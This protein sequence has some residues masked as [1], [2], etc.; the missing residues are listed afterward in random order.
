MMG[1]TIGMESIEGKGSTFWFTARF[2]LQDEQLVNNT[3]TSKKVCSTIAGRRLLIVEDNPALCEILSHHCLSWGV[4]AVIAESGKSAMAALNKSVTDGEVFDFISLDYQ[5]PDTDGL[6]LAGDIRQ[7][8]G[9]SDVPLF[10]LTAADIPLNNEVLKE[11][12]IHNAMRKPVSPKKL[13]L[14]LAA[15]LGAHIDVSDAQKQE[16]MIFAT[17]FKNLRVLVAE[18]NAVNRMVIKG[19]LGKFDITPHMAENG[20]EALNMVK[21]AHKPFDMILMD[22]EMPEM[23][24]FDATRNIRLYE[25]ESGMPATAIVALT[26]HAMQEHREA[27]YAVGM[28]HYLCKP[29]TMNDLRTAFEK[30]GFLKTASQAMS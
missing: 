25:K 3:A 4:E 27:V 9:F 13:K 11:H 20:L 14:E 29:V 22:C 1:G 23:D 7:L 5:L 30:L 19:L 18:D 28:N 24:G 10:M 26:A 16:P 12:R 2:D 15:L 8:P 17:A 6:S 21:S